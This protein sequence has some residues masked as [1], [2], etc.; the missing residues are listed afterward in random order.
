MK[1]GTFTLSDYRA[2]INFY[3]NDMADNSHYNIL[4]ILLNTLKEN[5][6]KVQIDQ[7]VF[8]RYSSIAQDY[9]EGFYNKLTFKSHR[10]PSGFEIKFFY[11]T[12]RGE[13]DFDKLDKMPYITKLECIKFI[14]IIKNKLLELGFKDVT[15]P[16][17]KFAVDN[18]KQKYINE[19]H[20]ENID[21][22]NFKLSDLDRQTTES[23]NNKDRDKNI[24]YNGQIKYFRDRNGYLQRGKV[25]HNINNMWWVITN[26][27]EYRNVASFELFDLNDMDKRHLKKIKFIKKYMNPKR[28]EYS[29]QEYRIGD[30]LFII[31]CRTGL[32]KAI[33]EY[34]CYKYHWSAS[35]KY[36]ENLLSFNKGYILDKFSYNK[37]LEEIDYENT[38]KDWKRTILEWRRNNDLDKRI[39]RELYDCIENDLDDTMSEEYLCKTFYD[40]CFD[41]D[42]DYPYEDFSVTN[43]YTNDTNSFWNLFEQ[44][45][46]IL[47]EEL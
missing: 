30:N 42:I 20:H 43:K 12:E 37:E 23:Y 31:N 3:S 28:K 13:Y 10:Y 27:I 21:N 38:I 17:Y 32:F 26:D 9:F 46:D 16:K 29:N 41:N 47:K 40:K 8:N 24:I 1:N 33:T 4:D 6:F 44:F 18:I 5:G 39:A 2:S 34:G 15:T 22:M 19:W 7:E 11:D 36:K 35:D 14:N 45:R 25:Y